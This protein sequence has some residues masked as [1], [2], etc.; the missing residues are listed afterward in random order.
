MDYE[1]AECPAPPV[2]G[3]EKICFFYKNVSS[4]IT[5]NNFASSLYK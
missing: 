3:F 5:W 1:E 2:S 4:R